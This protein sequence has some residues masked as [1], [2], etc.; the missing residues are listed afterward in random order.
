MIVRADTLTL[1]NNGAPL[2]TYGRSDRGYDYDGLVA[3]LIELKR[4]APDDKRIALLLD[5]GIPYEILVSLMDS[6][7]ETTATVAEPA[8]E[9]FPEVSVGVAPPAE[10]PAVEAPAAEVA[11]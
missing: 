10:A 8:A 3:K 1:A 5:P 9:L 6:V 7:R 2:E 4:A 11:P